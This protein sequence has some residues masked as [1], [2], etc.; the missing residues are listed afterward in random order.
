MGVGPGRH[1][2]SPLIAAMSFEVSF[3]DVPLPTIIVIFLNSTRSPALTLVSVLISLLSTSAG[4]CYVLPTVN[5]SHVAPSCAKQ[6]KCAAINSR[7]TFHLSREEL[8]SA[9]AETAAADDP[10]LGV[11]ISKSFDGIPYS[12]T[13][14]ARR[15]NLTSVCVFLLAVRPPCVVSTTIIILALVILFIPLVIVLPMSLS[16]AACLFQVYYSDA[17]TEEMDATDLERFLDP[18]PR[19]GATIPPRFTRDTWVVTWRRWGTSE[20]PCLVSRTGGD[21]MNEAY[22]CTYPPC[23]TI[24]QGGKECVHCEAVRE[25]LLVGSVDGDYPTNI[26]SDGELDLTPARYPLEPPSIGVPSGFPAQ[27]FRQVALLTRPA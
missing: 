6:F 1:L 24:M 12:G 18:S 17:D 19:L 27:V 3:S 9:L 14:V 20:P 23:K 7:D 8:E 16:P 25:F 15:G 4:L 21:G 11:Q 2:D 13:T 5:P 10:Y 26:T 22:A